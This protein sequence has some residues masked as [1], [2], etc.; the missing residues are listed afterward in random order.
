MTQTEYCIWTYAKGSIDDR[1]RNPTTILYP[2]TMWEK[3]S[4]NGG[5]YEVLK[6]IIDCIGGDC[7]MTM[8]IRF[9]DDSRFV[10]LDDSLEDPI[11]ERTVDRFAEIIGDSE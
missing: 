4:R 8:G 2:R 10:I 7:N 6:V 3:E 9:V 5:L 1:D 11:N